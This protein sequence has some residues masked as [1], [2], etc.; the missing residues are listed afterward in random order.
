MRYKTC[1]ILKIDR[2]TK[3]WFYVGKMDYLS[4]T[5]LEPMLDERTGTVYVFI[6]GIFRQNE[7]SKTFLVRVDGDCK[8][9]CTWR[10]PNN[11][12]NT[13]NQFHPVGLRM[14][15]DDDLIITFFDSCSFENRRDPWLQFY[16]IRVREDYLEMHCDRT[17]L[18]PHDFSMTINSCF[19]L[20]EPQRRL[21]YFSYERG[22]LIFSEAT[23]EWVTYEMAGNSALDK[24]M[25]AIGL[26]HAQEETYQQSKN[27]TEPLLRFRFHSG[28]EIFGI[29]SAIIP[30][31]LVTHYCY[32]LHIDH[33]NLTYSFRKRFILEEPI[34]TNANH[35]EIAFGDDVFSY[36]E[37]ETIKVTTLTAIPTLSDLTSWKIS[38]SDL[39][40]RRITE[41]DLLPYQVP[42]SFTLQAYRIRHQREM[43][44][45][46]NQLHQCMVPQEFSGHPERWVK[47][48]GIFRDWI[49]GSMEEESGTEIPVLQFISYDLVCGREGEEP[50]PKLYLFHQSIEA[51]LWYITLLHSG[52]TFEIHMHQVMRPP[53]IFGAHAPYYFAVGT[54]CKMMN[55]IAFAIDPIQQKFAHICNERGFVIYDAPS[56]SWIK[57]NPSIDSD[58]AEDGF[59]D[60]PPYQSFFLRSQALKTYT[61]CELIVGDEIHLSQT[62]IEPEGK[63]LQRLYKL[64]ID[65]D[66][67]EFT[68]KLRVQLSENSPSLITRNSMVGPKCIATLRSITFD[69]LE[70]CAEQREREKKFDT[71]WTGS[72]VGTVIQTVYLEPLDLAEAAILKVQELYAEHNGAGIQCSILSNEEIKKLIRERRVD[73]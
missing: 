22:L 21:A 23:M 11:T 72:T 63:Q 64:I 29:L 8:E 30:D 38:E 42:Q 48:I 2:V 31:E 65:Y 43:E 6:V 4:M 44:A 3:Q 32:S 19:T 10:F 54:S 58:L 50:Y 20:S 69:E 26:Y 56:E 41:A 45:I 15:W 49:Y 35:S 40:E 5:F 1:Q 17:G 55:K 7:A 33:K 27:S 52:D 53:E 24:E 36:A 61:V 46:E 71:L 66:K 12:F 16:S 39:E 13:T 14:F 25:M 47:P 62:S 57:Y 73:V 18:P 70:G 37:Q 60:D 67:R 34:N 68:L 51:T 9:L 59:L 28:K